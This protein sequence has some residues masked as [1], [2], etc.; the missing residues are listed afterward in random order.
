MDKN[1]LIYTVIHEGKSSFMDTHT[2][3]VGQRFI[4][5]KEA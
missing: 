2:H 3:E 1:R 5:L 4:Y